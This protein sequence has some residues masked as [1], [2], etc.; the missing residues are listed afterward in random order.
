M[1]RRNTEVI[2]PLRDGDRLSGAEYWRRYLASPE[3]TRAELL[4]GVVYLHR[5]GEGDR[6]PEDAHMAPANDGL[7]GEPQMGL[8]TWIGHYAVYTTG[9]RA[10]LQP[11]L[12]LPTSQTKPEPDSLLRVLPECGG[13][14]RHDAKGWLHGV[15]EL[16]CEMANTS[17]A[18]DL[19]V[20][21]DNYE[22]NGIAEYIV[23][24]TAAGLFDWFVL[25]RKTYVPLAPDPADGYLKSIAFPG[26]WL[27]V[28]AL[29]A[30]DGRTVLAVLQKGLA[31]AEHAAFEAKLAATAAKKAKPKKRKS[32]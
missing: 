13:G 23:W 22:A 30:G 3:G 4:S 25:K 18:T 5:R 20:K 11:T 15:P 10:S 9:T 32:P 19:G 27:D 31:T 24:R 6:F 16:V 7:H 17:A 8:S 26:L 12:N 14:S 29:L 1:V 28:A 2:P 21:Y